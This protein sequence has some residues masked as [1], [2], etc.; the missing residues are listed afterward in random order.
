MIALS[1]S[2]GMSSVRSNPKA[3]LRS[4]RSLSARNG[5]VVKAE[6]PAKTDMLRLSVLRHIEPAI[7]AQETVAQLVSRHHAYCLLASGENDELQNDNNR[8]HQMISNFQK[9]IN[10]AIFRY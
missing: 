2:P 9:M 7:M 4:A 8:M 5:Q 3:T 1:Y 10:S 6:M